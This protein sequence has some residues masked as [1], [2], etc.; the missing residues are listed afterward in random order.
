MPAGTGG[1]NFVTQAFADCT[2]PPGYSPKLDRVGVSSRKIY[3]ADGAR[4]SSATVAPDIDLN[5]NAS[6]GGAFS[7]VGAFTGQSHSWDRTMA[8]GNGSGSGIDPR[9]YAYRHGT[10]VQRASG[11][12]YRFNAGFFDGHAETLDDLSG[13][14]P[15]LWLPTGSTL[16]ASSFDNLLPD[17]S[18]V[19]GANVAIG[20][21]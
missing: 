2:P 8:P 6:G 10:L 4:Y 13:A 9:I 16:P 14:D 12:A 17:V 11:G 19:Y 21:Q 18:R 7:D 20:I 15:S 1:R 5:Y 3:I